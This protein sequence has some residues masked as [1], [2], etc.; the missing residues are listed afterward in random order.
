MALP[1]FNIY[2]CHNNKKPVSSKSC[3]LIAASG[4]NI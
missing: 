3:I 1:N 2:F 4:S